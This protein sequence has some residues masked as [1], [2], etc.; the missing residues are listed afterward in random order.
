MNLLTTAVQALIPSTSLTERITAALTSATISSA[1]LSS[2][3]QEVER[4]SLA[5]KE[6]AKEADAMAIDPTLGESDAESAAASAQSASFVARRLEA[7][8][9][10]IA[11]YRDQRAQEEREAEQWA[12]YREAEKKRDAI[13]DRIKREYPRLSRAIVELIKEAIDGA[14]A[15]TL[16]NKDL[17][18]G[19]DPLD[20]PEGKARGFR[21]NG[22]DGTPGQQYPTIKLASSFIPDAERFEWTLWPVNFRGD[23]LRAPDHSQGAINQAVQYREQK[24]RNAK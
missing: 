2:I 7:A 15:V 6:T 1:A 10:R 22:R 24:A 4:A 14:D 8:R 17:P 11:A 23:S 19:A 20:T 16:A 5:A 12:K 9:A 3:L 18:P 13:A 21:E